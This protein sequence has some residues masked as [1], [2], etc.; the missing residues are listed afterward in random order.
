[1]HQE[2]EQLSV[3]IAA[4]GF[5]G[6]KRAHLVNDQQILF[7]KISYGIPGFG[8]DI[9]LLGDIMFEFLPDAMGEQGLH[10]PGAE[11]ATSL[12][13]PLDKIGDGDPVCQQDQA[14]LGL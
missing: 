1:L 8:A 7:F 4:A 9:D 10:I 5:P 11:S 14:F 6:Q 13:D 12:A 3:Q 2:I